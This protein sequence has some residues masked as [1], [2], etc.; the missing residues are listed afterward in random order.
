MPTRTSRQAASL[1]FE[2]PVEP[3]LAKLVDTLPTEGGFFYEPKWD[4]FRA[5]AYIEKAS[6]AKDRLQ[7]STCSAHRESRL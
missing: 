3:M 1:P 5:L 4:G 2:P 7:R 6:P